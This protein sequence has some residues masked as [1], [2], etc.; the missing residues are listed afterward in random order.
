[1]K[2]EHFDR[3]LV[4]KSRTDWDLKWDENCSVSFRFLNWYEMFQPF[5]T[6]RNGNLDIYIYECHQ[7]FFFSLKGNRLI[8]PFSILLKYQSKFE[9]HHMEE[10]CCCQYWLRNCN[11]FAMSLN[12]P[13]KKPSDIGEENQLA[14]VC[15]WFQVRV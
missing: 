3:N 13:G 2:P 15:T 1:M 9:F 14:I 12:E 8:I 7:M 10:L 4:K 6:K 11:H 5:R